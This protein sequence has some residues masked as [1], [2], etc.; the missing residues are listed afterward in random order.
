MIERYTSDVPAI[1]NPEY[2]T[3]TREAFLFGDQGEIF[4]TE[5]ARDVFYTKLGMA[6]L[7]LSDHWT[8]PFPDELINEELDSRKATEEMLQKWVT[9]EILDPE[10]PTQQCWIEMASPKHPIHHALQIEWRIQDGKQIPIE[11]R[12][13][14]TTALIHAYQALEDTQNTQAQ[15]RYIVELVEQNDHVMRKLDM[16]L[17][18]KEAPIP[19]FPVPLDSYVMNSFPVHEINTDLY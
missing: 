13:V 7:W 4:D 19:I 2:F 11:E 15:L 10:D 12:S 9:E 17:P 8:E 3:P 14:L 16:Q 5:V 18:W 1:P 6:F